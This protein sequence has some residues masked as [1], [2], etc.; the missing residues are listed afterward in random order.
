MDTT[1][2][3]NQLT[4][5]RGSEGELDRRLSE[6]DGKL[7]AWLSLVQAQHAALVKLARK[8]VPSAVPRD[9]GTLIRPADLAPAQNPSPATPDDALLQTLDGETAR[10]I[11]IKRRLCRGSRSVQEL[12][13]EYRAAQARAQKPSKP[14]VRRGWWRRTND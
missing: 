10:A 5:L 7:G 12:L 4:A 8:V 13:E 1:I 9:A 6:L 2:L 3:H 14:T 11:R